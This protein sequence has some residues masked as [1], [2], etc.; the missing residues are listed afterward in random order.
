MD[1]P[2][3]GGWH[4]V[5][6][7]MDKIV[8]DFTINIATANGTGS[9]S[10]NLILLQTLFD[11]G[12]PVSGKN[13]FPSN[14]SGLP[15]WYIVRLSEK[16]YQAPGDRTHIQI[17][18]N[19]ATWEEDLASLEPG[20][21]VIW[22]M[23][24]KMAMEREDVISYPVPMTKIA[25]KLNPK[26]ARMIANVVYVG[27]LAELLGMDQEVL[28]AAISKQFGGKE[29]AIELNAEAARL[30]RTYFAEELT[31]SD[32]YSVES[33]EIEEGGFFIEGNEAIALGSVFGGIQMLGWYPIT[34]SSSVA[35]GIISWLPKLRTNEGKATYAVIQAEDE[36]AAA[37]MI[38]GAG[39]AGARGLT[40]TSG[41]G[42]SLMQEFIGLAYFAEVPCV[43]WDINR[44]GPST[45]LP[46]RTQQGD[47][48]MLYES[49]HGDT[50]HIVFI[51]GTVEECFEFGWKVFD[52]SEKYQTPVFGFS[53]LDLGMNK[54]A[55]RG[56]EYPDES[57]DR[58][59][60]VLTQ[61]QMDSIENYGRY[62]DVD[63]DGIP[64]RTLP[65]SGL[66]PI[67]YRG[68]GHDED[69]TYSEKPDVYYKLMQRLG[70]KIDGAR[71]YLPAPIIKE[72]EKQELGVIFYGSM[73]N[74]IDEIEDIVEEKSGKKI[75][76]C[77]V[78]ALP[79][80]SEVEAFMEKHEKIIVVEINR[81][82]QLYGI[83]RKEYPLHLL[84]K[85]LSVAY[86][87]GMP[88]RGRLYAERIL[89][90]LEEAE[91]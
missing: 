65:G 30:G 56:F 18:V 45:G 19:P 16:G 74:T 85:M 40:A 72:D 10:A 52:A 23:D 54:W 27:V 82:A 79:L 61:E 32:A 81:D 2:P 5:G 88:P 73:E 43:F 22:N 83:M 89:D 66:D 4:R 37:G 28:E 36:L 59:K 67:L 78:R 14:I 1:N 8:N 80:H 6:A 84:S 12:I 25:R 50:K 75:S 57:M 33:R 31:K 58:G 34:P 55:C 21:V 7:E 39:W 91:I 70:R 38:I 24:S 90:V 86:S 46:T 15:T 69:G 35:E 44:V 17:L 76:T 68:T 77:R 41:P 20:T 13:L 63:G 3:P 9:Q 87:D 47:L 64:Y 11:M 29:K 26:L 60:V 48:T 53:D 71:D 42:I 49:S 62:R 51:P